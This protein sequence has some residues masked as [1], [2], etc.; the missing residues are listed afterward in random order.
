MSKEKLLTDFIK[1]V[2]D[3]GVSKSDISLI[4]D[5]IGEKFITSIHN[6]N[7]I[8]TERSTFGSDEVM[9][10]THNYIV[11][12]KSDEKVFSYSDILWLHNRML[13]YLGNVKCTLEDINKNYSEKTK[14][15]MLTESLFFS[16][17][18]GKA[19]N[20]FYNNTTIESYI[21]YIITDIASKLDLQINQHVLKDNDKLTMLNLLVWKDNNIDDFIL[22]GTGLQNPNVTIKEIFDSFDGMH[23]TLERLELVINNLISD[24]NY[25]NQGTLDVNY[26]NKIYYIWEEILKEEDVNIGFLRNIGSILEKINR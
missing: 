16:M 15:T 4:E 8:T 13:S 20:I 11:D 7:S 25:L 2:K 6:I 26:K 18:D 3:N 22:R 23:M 21:R 5:S 1:S 19:F 24:Y 12:I 9:R 17:S 14:N 10:I